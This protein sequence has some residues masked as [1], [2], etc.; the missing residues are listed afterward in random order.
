MKKPPIPTYIADH[1]MPGGNKWLLV[2][3]LAIVV[4]ILIYVNYDKN[5]DN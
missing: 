4:L 5:K 2:T 3:V 1:P